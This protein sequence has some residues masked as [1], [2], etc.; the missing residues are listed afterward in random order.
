[1]RAS[2]LVLLVVLSGHC[3]AQFLD[4]IAEFTRERPRVVVK[5]DSRGSFVANRN[6]GFWGVKVGL[7]HAGRFQYGIGYAFLRRGVSYEREVPG[8]GSVP[9]EL[10]FG[11]VTPYVEYAFY[12][13]G[14][15]EVR[16]P[17]Q[18]G[19]GAGSLVYQD[20]EGERRR[21][22]HSGVFLYEPS[23]TVQYRFLKYLGAQAGWGFRL[24][25]T[26]GTLGEP[27][28]APIYIVGL[29]VFFA[30]LHRDVRGGND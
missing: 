25:F 14:P 5:L 2:W 9:V 19:I 11:Y 22:A 13:R 21:Y 20:E 26:N 27:L 17:V 24:A 29:K 30:D 1:M 7:E 15:W 4:S 23:M 16:I 12:Q 10:R 6:V 28:T 18:F 3:R 8:M